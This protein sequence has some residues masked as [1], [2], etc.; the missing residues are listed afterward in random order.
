MNGIYMDKL[1]FKERKKRKIQFCPFA[2]STAVA[3]NIAEIP[4]S[5]TLA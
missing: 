3:A 4:A 2:V 5:R 1:M